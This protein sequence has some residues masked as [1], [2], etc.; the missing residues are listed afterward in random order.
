MVR[1][2]SGMLLCCVLI[3]M[4]ALNVTAAERLEYVLFWNGL[5][6]GS[7]A[8][9]K[10][11]Q[12]ERVELSSSVTSTPLAS[13][14]YTVNDQVVS[15]LRRSPDT[16][17]IGTP[18]RYHITLREG[19]HYR[20]KEYRFD[21][22]TKRIIYIDNKDAE[23]ADFPLVPPV[24]DPLSSIYHI[25]TLPLV[26]GRPVYVTVFDNKRVYKMEVKVLRRETIKTPAGSFTTL[27]VQPMMQ[28]E[29]FFSRRGELYLWLTDDA[30]RLPVQIKTKIRIGTVTGQLTGG[31]Y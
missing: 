11:E 12:G 21:Y 26:I 9:E 17:G 16:P 28:S 29:G 31:S 14:V 4:T 15:S 8:L 22:R 23:R 20:D 10:R 13:V 5:A 24:F 2:I 27:L 19:R 7:A 3:A 1:I 30:R 18:E 6:A 25:R